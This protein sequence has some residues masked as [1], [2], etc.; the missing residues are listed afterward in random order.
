MITLCNTK[1]SKFNLGCSHFCPISPLGHGVRMRRL[2][3]A[4][5]ST[6]IQS[7]ETGELF[8][9]FESNFLKSCWSVRS[10]L[11][12]KFFDVIV[13]YLLTWE[14]VHVYF[15]VFLVAD[16][17]ISEGSRAVNNA[18][19]SG[20]ICL[21]PE[22]HSFTGDPTAAQAC[23]STSVMLEPKRG[24]STSATRRAAVPDHGYHLMLLMCLPNQ[25]TYLPSG[26]GGNAVTCR[27]QAA[28]ESGNV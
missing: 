11:D 9:F 25:R 19:E 6:T 28:R 21:T 15:S 27:T 24:L 26:L 16:N 2:A 13:T 5:A 20:S 3:C 10:P 18:I 4:L 17:S 8:N 22:W 1:P 7:E 14:G 12:L 23:L